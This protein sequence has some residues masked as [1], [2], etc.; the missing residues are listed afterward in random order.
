MSG[1]NGR[2][3]KTHRG[4]MFLRIN[5]KLKALPFTAPAHA[6]MN[7]FDVIKFFRP[8]YCFLCFLCFSAFSCV[9]NLK[10]S[11]GSYLN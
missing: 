4:P 2:R 9:I 7:H 1:G 6:Q 11:Q 5:L 3:V 10:H 8:K